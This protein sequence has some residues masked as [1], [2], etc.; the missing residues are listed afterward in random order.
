MI[1]TSFRNEP[2]CLPGFQ[3]PLTWKTEQFIPPRLQESHVNPSFL[4][5]FLVC[6]NSC[7][8]NH[9]LPHSIP[10]ALPVEAYQ[11]AASSS[12]RIPVTGRQ[13]SCILTHLPIFSAADCHIDRDTNGRRERRVCIYFLINLSSWQ[14]KE[15]TIKPSMGK[16][17][18]SDTQNRKLLLR[19]MLSGAL[20][21]YINVWLPAE[22]F[23]LK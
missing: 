8:C 11:D 3:N 1:L 6:Q 19:C 12:C 15:G 14:V 23:P 5:R 16:S 17:H 4:W 21:L 9:H 7:W 20:G 22:G 13:P 2:G 18:V 10:P